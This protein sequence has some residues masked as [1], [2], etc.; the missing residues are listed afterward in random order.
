MGTYEAPGQISRLAIALGRVFALGLAVA[1]GRVLALGLSVALGLAAA[2]NGLR[3]LSLRLRLLTLLDSD[4]L[5]ERFVWRQAQR[6]Y[7]PLFA[8][9]IETS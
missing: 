6:S 5:V 4:V 1:L 8:A 2:R 7:L 3:L 9:T